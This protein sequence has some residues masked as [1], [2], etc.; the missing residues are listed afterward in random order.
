M[1][2]RLLTR[3][4]TFLLTRV[5]HNAEQSPGIDINNGGGDCTSC[6]LCVPSCPENLDPSKLIALVSL[7]SRPTLS[8]DT[9]AERIDDLIE[10]NINACTACGIC[11]QAC[12]SNVPLA[13][14]LAKGVSLVSA[15]EKERE[16]SDHWKARFAARQ[17]R[18]ATKILGRQA[19]T[20][21]I[22]NKI[23]S[24]STKSNVDDNQQPNSDSK[25]SSAVVSDST[26]AFSR[27][28]A[29]ND[30]AA[31]VAR[32]KAKREAKLAAADIKRRE[33]E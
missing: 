29:Q 12:P 7:A 8:S 6:K 26:N 20:R 17:V 31:A 9:Q 27:S 3:I 25:A 15:E 21:D 5:A 22:V 32:V 2:T 10:S 14:L 18:M 13:Q 4:N 30:V 23:T 1:S 28:A 19:K 16:L 11:T 24:G 33:S